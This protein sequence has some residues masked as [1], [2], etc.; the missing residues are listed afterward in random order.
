MGNKLKERVGQISA[1]DRE[2]LGT[3]RICRGIKFVPS[4]EN[5]DTRT[6]GLRHQALEANGGREGRVPCSDLDF[7]LGG[8]G[9]RE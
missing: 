2:D 7:G 6:E 4:S 8:G 3:N 5:E 9:G 1:G